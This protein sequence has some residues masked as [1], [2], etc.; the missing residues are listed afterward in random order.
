MKGSRF[1]MK[2]WF[3]IKSITNNKG[4]MG[5]LKTIVIGGTVAAV[6][7]TVS[8]NGKNAVKGFAEAKYK[9]I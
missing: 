1:S 7:G 2:T 5:L 3:I 8:R 4:V 9:K 6:A